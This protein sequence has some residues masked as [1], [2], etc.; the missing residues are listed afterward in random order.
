MA[1]EL[2]SSLGNESLHIVA[3]LGLW[4]GGASSVTKSWD[5][6]AGVR[7]FAANATKLVLEY[8]MYRKQQNLIHITNWRRLV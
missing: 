3:G 6:N 8:V 5:V 2:S 1:P 4:R 7:W